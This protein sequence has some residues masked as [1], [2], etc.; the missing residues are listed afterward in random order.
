QS[1]MK[2]TT[3]VMDADR[4]TLFLI[5]FSKNELW[6]K[7]AEGTGISEIRFPLGLGIA[8]HVAMNG[9]TVN[10]PDAYQD[11][12]FNQGIDAK[13]G[14]HTRSI[15]CAPLKDETGKIIGVLQVLNKKTGLFT[16]HDEKLI[17][18]FATQVSKV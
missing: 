11:P 1:L 12:R 8:S 18:A 16:T 13:T 17:A 10:I 6:S 4:S 14:Y 7:V 2:K 15:M 9:E 3:Q 5:D